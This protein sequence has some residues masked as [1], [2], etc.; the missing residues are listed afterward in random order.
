M[1]QLALTVKPRPASQQG[2]ANSRRLRNSGL[3][4]AEVYGHGDGNL[5]VA[6]PGK[7]FAKMLSTLKG[8]NVLFSLQVEGGASNVLVLVKEI[9]FGRMDHSIKHVDFLKIKMDEKIRVR[10]PVRVLNIDKCEGVK[11]GGNVQH[12]LRTLDVQCL[13]GLVPDHLDVDVAALV[14]GASVHASDLKVPEGVK[15]ITDSTT[16]VVM[17]SAPVAEEKVAEA[18]AGAVPVAGAAAAATEPEVLTAKK[19]EEAAAAGDAKKPA[20]KAKK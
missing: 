17:V 14:I 9:Q 19:K 11:E 6:L 2:S 12:L 18:V 15:I 20:D 1:K 4:P 13:P 5:S 10:V 16:V 7:E 3:V 8:E